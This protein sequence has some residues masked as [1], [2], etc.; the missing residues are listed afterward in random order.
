[1]IAEALL[2]DLL[3]VWPVGRLATVDGEGSPHIVPVVFCV[4]DDVLYSPVDGKR[5]RSQNLKRLQNA[6][7]NPNFSLLLDE[8]DDDWGR[9]WWVRLDGTADVYRPDAE[10]VAQ[11]RRLFLAKYPQYEDL[12]LSGEDA[13]FLRLRSKKISAWSQTDL[14]ANVRRAL[15]PLN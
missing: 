15:I 12:P 13:V 6:A 7:S 10:H 5:K 14:E 9:L 4:E 8:Y 2:H 3:A 11:L 1:M